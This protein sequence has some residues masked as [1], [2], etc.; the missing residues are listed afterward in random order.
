MDKQ[1]IVI[2]KSRGEKNCRENG[3]PIAQEIKK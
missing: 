2:Y 3:A 1:M